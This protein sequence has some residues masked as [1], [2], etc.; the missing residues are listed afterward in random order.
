V[1][2]YYVPPLA[3]VVWEGLSRVVGPEN[4]PPLAFEVR[5]GVARAVRCHN[6]PPLAFEVREG[7][8]GPR[9]ALHSH[10]G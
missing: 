7:V 6:S 2:H 10:L 9:M 5:E 8:V 4:G 3:F 1:S